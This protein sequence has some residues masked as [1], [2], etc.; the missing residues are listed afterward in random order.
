MGEEPKRPAVFAVGAFPP[1]VHGLS[2][3]NEAIAERLVGRAS[4]VKFDT[5]GGTTRSG[6]VRS[7]CRL[8]SGLLV[9]RF[10]VMATV[11][12]P[13]SIYIGLSGGRGQLIDGMFALIGN[14]LGIPVFF[15]HHSF[16]YLNKPSRLTRMVFQLAGKATH[17]ALC[18]HMAA[19]LKQL[20]PGL[21]RETLV[22]SNTALFPVARSQHIRM[23]V[24]QPLTLGFLSN[25]TREKGIFEFFD[26]LS[27]LEDKDLQVRAIIAGPVADTI[28]SEFNAALTSHPQASHIGSVSGEEKTKFYESIDLL[29]FPSR[30]ENEAEPLTV[31]E[32]IGFGVPVIASDKGCIPSTLRRGGGLFVRD[33]ERMVHSIADLIVKVAKSPEVYEQLS[34]DAVASVMD[35]AAGHIAA[36]SKL[37]G[38][39]TRTWPV[40]EGMVVRADD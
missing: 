6:L 4:I 37:L 32:A 22:L 13:S 16:R 1:P 33:D 7:L 39:L 18:S 15:H 23:R 24:R 17:I 5:A 14:L 8:G 28:A 30:Y 35:D 3:V 19:R 27:V 29:V 25:I 11:R 38:M 31:N 26:V 40:S 20:Y 9:L 36:L 2:M 21:V 10:A 12:R 34:R